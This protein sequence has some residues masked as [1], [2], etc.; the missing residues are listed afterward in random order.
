LSEPKPGGIA[1]LGV[2]TGD[3]A[4]LKYFGEWF[5]CIQP[6]PNL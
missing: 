3:W 5:V 1:R 6:G 2:L 4:E